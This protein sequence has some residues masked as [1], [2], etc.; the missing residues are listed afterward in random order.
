MHTFARPTFQ[1]WCVLHQSIKERKHDKLS[2]LSTV[3]NLSVCSCL[4]PFRVSDVL[5]ASDLAV[6]CSKTHSE[7]RSVNISFLKVAKLNETVFAE[8]Q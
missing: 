7:H 2:L 3:L 6:C 4:F 8:R 5:E 1:H